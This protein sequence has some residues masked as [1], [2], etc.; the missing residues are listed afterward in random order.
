MKCILHVGVLRSALRVSSRGN[1][2]T[3]NSKFVTLFCLALLTSLRLFGA[4][5][6]IN[7][8]MY[9]PP[10]AIPEDPALE[11]VELHNTGTNTVN[12]AGWRFSKGIDYLFPTN[13]TIGPGG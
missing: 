10:P 5:I 9:H 6:V 11:W 1:R 4:E 8:I 12:L 3:R 7:E 2:D 13:A